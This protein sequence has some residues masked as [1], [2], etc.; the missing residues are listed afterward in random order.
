MSFLPW[1]FIGV[2]YQ[3]FMD[4]CKVLIPEQWPTLNVNFSWNYPK[5]E[6]KI[7][8]EASDPVYLRARVAKA[9]HSALF[10]DG[11]ASLKFPD[12]SL[13]RLCKAISANLKVDESQLSCIYDWICEINEKAGNMKIQAGYKLRLHQARVLFS[14]G[15]VFFQEIPWNPK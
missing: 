13:D 6:D 3:E 10:F 4:L 9:I 15:R 12:K 14:K 7:V 5:K 8:L 11:Y 1:E 2:S